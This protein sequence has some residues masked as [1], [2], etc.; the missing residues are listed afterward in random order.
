M[1]LRLGLGL[2]LN[3]GVSVAGYYIFIAGADG[4]GNFDPGPTTTIA[5]ATSNIGGT[6]TWSIVAGSDARISINSSSGVISSSSVISSG[7]TAEFIVRADNGTIAVEFPFTAVG[8]AAAYETESTALFARFS[9]DPGATRKGH[10]NT[11]IAALKTAGVWSKLDAFYMLAA[12]DA[13]A[14]QRN[15]IADQFNLS[16]VNSPTFTADQ[17]YAG[18]GTN[19][20]LSTGFNPTVGSP[21]FTVASATLGVWSRTNAT[22]AAYYD[23]G[24][25]IGSS[26]AVN[27]RSTSGSTMRG[28]MTGGTLKNWGSNPSSVGHF[29]LSRTASNLVTSYVNGSSTGTDTVAGA[30]F[31]SDTYTILKAFSNYSPRQIACAHIGGGLNSTEVAALYNA[32]NT[33]LVAVGAA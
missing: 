29:A 30:S 33:Y 21:K 5:T 6:I 12:H 4:S 25:A 2:G 22:N 28:Q 20:Y 15:W 13:Q 8:T 31:T 11:L 24:N 7:D 1:S 14:A 23:I 18:N 17:G 27:P 10:I 32:I 3:A 19:A 16:L 9:A 26:S